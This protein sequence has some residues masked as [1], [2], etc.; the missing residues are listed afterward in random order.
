[1]ERAII[2]EEKGM[3]ESGG[4]NWEFQQLT[5]SG[6]LRNLGLAAL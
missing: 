5:H 1:M 3:T 2:Q 4:D 6:K